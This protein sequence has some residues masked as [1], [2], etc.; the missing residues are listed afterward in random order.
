MPGRVCVAAGAGRPSPQPAQ[1]RGPCP[2][3]LP[4]V[5]EAAAASPAA[6]ADRLHCA[7]LRNT[8]RP[9]FLKNTHV[10]EASSSPPAPDPAGRSSQ[11]FQQHGPLQTSFT[12]LRATRGLCPRLILPRRWPRSGGAG[13]GRPPS[14]TLSSL[15][16]VLPRRVAGGGWF[17]SFVGIENVI[18]SPSAGSALAVA[19][20][21]GRNTASSADAPFS[22]SLVCS[23][24]PVPITWRSPTPVAPGTSAAV[25]IEGLTT[26]GGAEAAADADEASPARPP[27]ACPAAWPPTGPGWCCSTARGSAPPAITH[28][29]ITHN[30]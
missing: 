30:V 23:P 18:L 28:S 14:P 21:P 5:R 10:F 4:D 12:G 2:L 3:R 25:S 13:H 15:A 16:H 20:S 8:L 26:R 9:R 11:T 22:V 27:L 1:P 19:L 24:A 29:L 7:S 17:Y 6:D